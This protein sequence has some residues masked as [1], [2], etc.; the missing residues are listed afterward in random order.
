M[1]K[2]LVRPISHWVPELG[3]C[4]SLP[5]VLGRR[6]IA[7]TLPLQLDEAE[8]EALAR[9]AETLRGVIGEVRKDF[10]LGVEAAEKVEKAEI[11]EAGDAVKVGGGE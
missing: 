2:H 3:C 11:V 7:R 10:T 5:V 6:G 8:N 9:S 1:D 4:L